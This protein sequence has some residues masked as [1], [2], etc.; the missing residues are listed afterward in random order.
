MDPAVKSRQKARECDE[1][2]LKDAPLG[3]I[4]L[5]LAPKQLKRAFNPL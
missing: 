1:V 4:F 2:T 3:A 5:P